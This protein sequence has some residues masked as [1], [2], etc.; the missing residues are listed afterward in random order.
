MEIINKKAI[1]VLGGSSDSLFMIKTAHEMGLLTVCVDQNPKSPGLLLAN[2]SSAIDFVNIEEVITFCN[3][4]LND[5][6]RLSGV[7]TMGC[8]IPHIVSKIASS[9]DWVGP[10][11]DTGQWAVNKFK[12]KNRF[13]EKGIPVPQFG[14]VSTVGEIE[15]LRQQWDTEIVIIKPTNQAGSKG[16]RIINKEDDLMLA[17]D[18]AKEYSNN[19]EILLEEFITGPQISTETVMFMSSGKTPGFADRV[20]DGMEAFLPAVIENGGWIPSKVEASLQKEVCTLVEDAALALG[21]DNGV[22]KGDVVICSK[23][24]PLIIE[25]AAR[26]SGGDFAESLVPLSIG[27]NY[28]KTAIEIALGGKE[29]ALEELNPKSNNAVANRY[30]FVHPGR[31]EGIRG[32]NAIKSISQIKKIDIFFKVGDILPIIDSHSKRTG[33][34]VVTDKYK[35][36]VQK[37]IEKVYEVIEF[38]VDGNWITGKPSDYEN[39]F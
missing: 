24:G 25:M 16:V 36:D 8:D 6:V 22:A 10:S 28:V 19:N 7:L 37:I 15:D 4:L 12:M 21:V 26:L 31:L 39:T 35:D 20:Y 29:V 1:L 33:V 14:L 9:F 32:L 2:Y 5:G 30:F 11:S 34:F 17:L 3:K 23:R 27:V 38:K 13:V 18:Y